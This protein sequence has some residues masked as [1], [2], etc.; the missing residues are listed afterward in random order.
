[1]S[2]L[3]LLSRSHTMKTVKKEKAADNFDK[4]M[5]TSKKNITLDEF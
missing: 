1:M 5:C 2:A 4:G 3:V